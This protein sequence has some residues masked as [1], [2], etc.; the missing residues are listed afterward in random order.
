VRI[1]KK[2]WLL[3]SA[4]MLS[5]IVGAFVLAFG[6]AYAQM[7]IS[8]LEDTFPQP[9]VIYDRHGNEAT[10]LSSSKIEFVPLE[11]VSM[12]LKQAIVATEDKRFYEHSGVDLQ[13]ILRALVR[14]IQAGEVVEGGSTITQQ[15]AKNLF[16]SSERTLSRKLKEAIT[17][18]KIEASY[19]KDEILELYL[20]HIYFGEGA[21]GVQ[22]AAQTYFGKKVEQ[23][24]LAESAM[25]AALPKAPSYY[26]PYKHPEK[27]LER[28]N[29]VL[30]LMKEQGYT[31]NEEYAAARNQEIAVVPEEQHQVKGDYP[32]YV[33][34]VLQEAAER[35]GLNEDDIL[36]KGFHIY[37]EL[38]PKIQT[39]AETVYEQGEGF[40]EDSKDQRIQS[41]VVLQDPHT[42]GLRAIVGGRGEHVFSGFNRATE[43]RRQPGSAIKPLVVYGPAIE[44]GLGPQTLLYDGPLNIG[45]Y[46]PRDWDGQYRGLVT[47]EEAVRQSWNIPAVWTLNE[48]GLSK[49][50]TYGKTLGLPLDKGDSHLGLALGGLSHGVSPLEMAQ[51]FSVFPALGEWRPAHA[52]AEIHSSDGAALAKYE[53]KP[54]R[55][56]EPRTAYTMTQL[57]QEVVHNGTGKRAQ[58]S[59]PTAGKTGTTQL[60]DTAEFKGIKGGKDAWFVG[61]TPELVGAVWMG[62]D[63]TDRTHVIDFSGGHYPALVFKA[64]MERAL[65]DVPV[66]AFEQ[67]ANM[68]A[69][70][71]VPPKKKGNKE[72]REAKGPRK[73]RGGAPW[74][75]KGPPRK[76]KGGPPWERKGR[77][78]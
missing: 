71:S 64:I 3:A 65:Q 13:S 18:I 24:T 29:L 58:L 50:M 26:S 68:A 77:G 28:R 20:N 27:A 45:G 2:G 60:P 30:S 31:T 70:T 61:Y 35:Y 1:N 76:E 33:D 66:V 34:Y 10:R 37:S 43:L 59:R 6:I 63:K 49:G 21:W 14:D 4:A 32:S 46:S 23:C 11:K 12:T 8:S 9:T 78:D 39:A 47:L 15:L 17:S 62:Y 40:P 22:Q 16:L 69:F 25:L 5:L 73:E 57:L 75:E 52:I 7:D 38:D 51:A 44:L 36:T 72:A 48:I 54:I 42:G 19:D 56:F 41:G 55:V 74:G 67:P 53:D